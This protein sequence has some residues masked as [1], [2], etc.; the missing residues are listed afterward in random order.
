MEEAAKRSLS[1]YCKGD[2]VDTCFLD[3]YHQY[4]PPYFATAQAHASNAHFA[5]LIE[6]HS[7]LILIQDHKW[8]SRAIVLSLL[9]SLH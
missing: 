3:V 8:G 7:V 9:S 1:D 4:Q 2:F 5:Q 6:L